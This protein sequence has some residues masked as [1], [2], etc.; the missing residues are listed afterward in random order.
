[1]ISK[2]YEV[3]TWKES[4]RGRA[5]EDDEDVTMA[6]NEWIEQRDQNFFLEG[7]KTLKQRREMCDTLRGNYAEKHWNDFDVS[8][9]FMYFSHYL[10]NAP[11]TMSVYWILSVLL[12]TRSMHWSLLSFTAARQTVRVKVKLYWTRDSSSIGNHQ[13]PVKT[14]AKLASKFSRQLSAHQTVPNSRAL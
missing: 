2:G 11:R 12:S 7:V 5:F 4:L 14:T 3:L 8:Q 6:V 13:W 1:M 10:L 9:Y